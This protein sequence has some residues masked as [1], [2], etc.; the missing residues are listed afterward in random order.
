[1]SSCNDGRRTGYTKL[2]V[3]ANLIFVTRAEAESYGLAFAQR[4][5][6]NGA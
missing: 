3:R 6:D 4:A 2:T 5:I 1:M